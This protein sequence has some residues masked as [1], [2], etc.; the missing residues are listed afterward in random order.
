MQLGAAVAADRDQRPG[1]AGAAELRL[2]K[3][4][5]HRIDERGA[6]MHQAFNRLFGEEAHLQVIVC[7][8]Q[9]LAIGD[10]RALRFGEQRRQ[11][12]QHR[13]GRS[14][15]CNCSSVFNKVGV[16]C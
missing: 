5:Q 9:Q 16:A 10:G 11:A 4:A 13:P 8:V 1:I 14:A 6:R 3:L 15:A 7:L 12:R 2:P